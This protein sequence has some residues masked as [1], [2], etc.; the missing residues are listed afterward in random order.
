METDKE[1]IIYEFCLLRYVPDIERGEFINV[2]LLMMCKRHKWL[3]TGIRLVPERIERLSGRVD[4]NLLERQLGV[5]KKRDVPAKD[6]PV[7]E[8]YRWMAAVKSAIIQTSPSHP[9]ILY[10]TPDSA[11]EA[12]E[13]KFDSLFNRLVE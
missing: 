5:F 9:G 6:L 10:T 2:G 13:N 11:R 8:K 12:L 7:E 1:K 4:L 3:R